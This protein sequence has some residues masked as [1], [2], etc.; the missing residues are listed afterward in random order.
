M[1][2]SRFDAARKAVPQALTSCR[3]LLG[4]WA[5]TAAFDGRLFTAA[6]LITLGGVLDGLD[7]FAA[8]A[9]G[10]CSR[11]GELFDCFADYLCFVIAPWA[12]A[13]SLLSPGQSALQDTLLALPVLMAAIRYAQNAL[14]LGAG[15]LPGL[16][17]VFFAFVCVATVF[18]DAE[19]L[20]GMPTLLI[21]LPA[22]IVIFS[23]LM[24]APIR[25]P[26]MAKF[27]G[28]SPVVLV[29]LALMP[30][31]ATKMLAGAM[32]VLGLLYVA[33]APMFADRGPA[34]A[35]AHQIR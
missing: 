34:H 20:L 15:D 31:V 30:F 14:V 33:L 22:F 19:G 2:Q 21:A 9:L 10:A 29:L 7:G 4:L 24:I 17:T 3:L 12:L 23:L 1:P 26:K 28:M 27:S 11:F 8:R 32:F 16:G 25:Y 13:R 6:T 18:L 35:R 5:L